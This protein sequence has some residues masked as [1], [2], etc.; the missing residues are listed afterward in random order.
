MKY[1]ITSSELKQK[2]EK[3]ET[4]FLL[5]VR[6]PYEHEYVNLGGKLIPLNQ[7]RV[8]F[9]ELDP[10]HEIVVYCHRGNRSAYAVNFLIQRG[11]QRVKNLV[12]G[13]DDWSQRVDQ[14]LPRY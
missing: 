9:K 11:F 8:R 3:G 13:I 2:I 12:G 1:E 4:V 5:D 7:L 6:E 10:E 14:D